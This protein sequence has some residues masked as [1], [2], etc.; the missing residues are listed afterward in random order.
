MSSSKKEEG[1][2]EKLHQ[3]F[4]ARIKAGDPEAIKAQRQIDAA[5]A[6]LRKDFGQPTWEQ[7]HRIVHS[8]M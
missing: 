7:L 5:R 2:A 8:A 1:I 6:Q 3:L 4:E